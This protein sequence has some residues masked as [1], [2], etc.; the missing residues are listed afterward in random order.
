MMSSKQCIPEVVV[1]PERVTAGLV[2]INDDPLGQN[3]CGK[4][5]GMCV[6]INTRV[7]CNLSTT[8]QHTQLSL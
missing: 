7:K 3:T 8:K 2:T 6:R 5:K 4:M 1:A